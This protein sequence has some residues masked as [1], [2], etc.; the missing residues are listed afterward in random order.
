[1][2][3]WEWTLELRGTHLVVDLAAFVEIW[4]QVWPTATKCR[5]ALWC[6]KKT[7]DHS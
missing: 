6:S 3:K 2:T 4:R 5:M 7:G 1:M